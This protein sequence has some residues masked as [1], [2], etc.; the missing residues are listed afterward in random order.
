MKALYK[1]DTEIGI[2]EVRK[3]EG[4]ELEGLAEWYKPFAYAGSET[5]TLSN[6]TWKDTPGKKS[7]GMLPGCNNQIWLLTDEEATNYINLNQVRLDATS[8]KVLSV[9]IAKAERINKIYAEA[10]NTGKPQE[11]R[12]YISNECLDNLVDCSFDSVV[13]YAMPDGTEKKTH[14]HCH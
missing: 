10:K 12:R 6:I 13:I 8:A 9:E 7:D 2:Y 3:L 1:N 4:K 11:L 14:N 5:Q